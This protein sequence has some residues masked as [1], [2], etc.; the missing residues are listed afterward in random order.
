MS[1]P[2]N[3]ALLSDSPDCSSGLARITRDLAD[4]IYKSN[5]GIRLATIGFNGVGSRDY[6]WQQYN[7]GP[8]STGMDMLKIMPAWQDF[9]REEGGI[10]LTIYDLPR[11]EAFRFPEAYGKPWL[12]FL[13]S[14]DMSLWGYFP[15]DSH[16]PKGLTAQTAEVLRA[17]DK[18]IAYGPYGQGVI[19]KA[20]EQLQ[21]PIRQDQKLV[22]LPHGI[23]SRVFKPKGIGGR[24]FLKREV[25]VD[26]LT[27]DNVQATRMLEVTDGDLL[28]GVNATNQA[29]K[30]WGST[31]EI[32]HKLAQENPLWKFWVHTDRLFNYWNIPDLVEQF[33]L[34]EKVFITQPP[35]ED[36]RLADL[37]SACDVTFANGLGEGYGYPIV[38]SQACGIPCVHTNFAGGP[39]LFNESI[40]PLLVTPRSLRL[41]GAYSFYRPIIDVD[42]TAECIKMA[43][44]N[45]CWGSWSQESA[46]ELDWTKVWPKWKTHLE[47]LLRDYKSKEKSDVA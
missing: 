41:D 10:L 29:R 31:F 22:A 38:E 43:A 21:E 34:N 1:K 27:R 30:D 8:F 16:T 36:E 28:L 7:V 18:V 12:N 26:V 25:R 4:R 17:F 19:E 47:L 20:I 6:P 13:G 40:K 11:L 3:L 23:D 32:F 42:T 14:V 44:S 35:I 39:D 46:G 2:I 15:I 9:A 5:L 37:Y 45:E 24:Q 33:D